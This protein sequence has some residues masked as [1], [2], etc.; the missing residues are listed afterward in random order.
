M[1]ARRPTLD[2]GSFLKA[3]RPTA[4]DILDKLIP[5]LLVEEI[6]VP[7]FGVVW[8]RFKWRLAYHGRYA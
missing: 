8:S 4:V 1:V 6:G 2:D 3:S 5:L 7:V